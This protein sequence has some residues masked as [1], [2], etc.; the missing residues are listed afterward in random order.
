MPSVYQKPILLSTGALLASRS[1]S[2]RGPLKSLNIYTNLCCQ[3]FTGPV[4]SFQ[5]LFCD[6]NT[7]PRSARHCVAGTKYPTLGLLLRRKSL[8]YIVVPVLRRQRVCGLLEGAEASRQ[9][10]FV[11]RKV[12]YAT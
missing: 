6:G 7:M 3:R 8:V 10:V 11:Y 9:P 5:D 4:D 1:S 12:L 2:L